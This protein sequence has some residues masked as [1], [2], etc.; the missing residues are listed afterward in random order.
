LDC[1]NAYM[2]IFAD[3]QVAEGTYSISA[4]IEYAHMKLPLTMIL[5]DAHKLLDDVAKDKTGR[6]ALACRVWKPGGEQQTWAMP[7]NEAIKDD[8]IILAGL[9]KKLGEDES[10]EPG[11]AS[12]LL[13]H[14]RETLEMLQG[15]SPMPNEAIQKM[16]I[17]DYMSSGLLD[18]IKGK[19]KKNKA[20][21]L[22]EPL[23]KQCREFRNK[24]ST[25]VY[26]ADGALMLRFLAK[27]GV[28]R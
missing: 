11:Y 23:L 17:A 16:L 27:K 18:G 22:I 13:Y 2:Q 28:E 19:D 7:W 6:D 15:S 1:R 21:A 14:I 8:A 5:K 26:T 20:K 10:G 12:K 25:G 4:A 9:A 24:Q 3:K